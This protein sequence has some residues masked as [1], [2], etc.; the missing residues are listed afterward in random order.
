ML[1]QSRLYKGKTLPQTGRKIYDD[2]PHFNII[3]RAIFGQIDWQFTPKLKTTIGLRYGDDQKHGY[4]RVRIINAPGTSIA[5][6]PLDLF[7]FLGNVGGNGVIST[8]FDPATGFKTRLYDDKWGAAT[9]TLGLQYN[10][11]D[12]TMVY[13]KYSR[14]YKAG[15]FRIG[16]DT[17]LGADPATDKETLDSFEVGMKTNFGPTL[18]VNGSIFYYD[19]KN[20][21]VPL[22]QPSATAGGTSNSILFNVPSA[23]SQG[24]EIETIWQP[25][26]NLQILANYSLLDTSIRSGTAIDPAD[27]CALNRDARRTTVTTVADAFCGTQVLQS[28]KGNTLPNAAKHRYTVNANYSWI[29]DPG[30][31][32]ASATY[33]WRGSQY[34]SIFDRTYFKAPSFD[35]VDARLTWRAEDGKYTVIGFAK[36]LFDTK[37][38]ANGAGGGRRA[39]ATN[40]RPELSGVLGISTTYELNPPRTYGVELQY[41]F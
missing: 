23:R 5:T 35:Q 11:D 12:D 24:I 18:Q 39:A 36:N 26:D 21:Q 15:G 34:G 41:R 4:E 40:G 9:G 6:L 13:A 16:I 31:L 38:Y 30:T 14:G 1:G 28:L 3:S 22:A 20:A 19:Y 8:T 25:I 7:P 2:R 32:T 17:S 10:P 33:V 37:G 27:T 29:F